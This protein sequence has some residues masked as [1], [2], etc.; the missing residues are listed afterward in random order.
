MESVLSECSITYSL[1]NEDQSNYF[2]EWTYNVSMYGDAADILI[3]AFRYRSEVEMD[4][5]LY[6]VLW[7]VS[8]GVFLKQ[9]LSL[10]VCLIIYSNL[11]INKIIISIEQFKRI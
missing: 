10:Y 5:E 8:N 4:G 2:P 3:D 7:L 6:D 11:T 1:E 9:I